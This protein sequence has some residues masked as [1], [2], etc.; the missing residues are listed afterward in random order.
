[1]NQPDVYWRLSAPFVDIV[2]MYSNAAENPGFI[3]GGAAG[4][5]QKQ[6]LIKT[7]STIARERKQTG[8]KALVFATHHP[9]FTSGGHSPSHVM[10]ADIDDA[11]RKAAIMPDLFLSGHSH[12]YQRYSRD[13][14]VNRATV[15][16]PYIVAGTG[17]IN[18]A[19]LPPATKK[20]ANGVTFEASKQGYGYLLVEIDASMIIVTF[21]AV[22]GA[23]KLEYERV[24]VNLQ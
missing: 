23:V 18:D 2:G 5:A 13:V 8:R 20:T 19:R 7:L 1:M 10:L 3:S 4:T 11:C 15:S 22:D 16:I 24:T 12:N 9:P 17:G 21:I 14:T 6:W